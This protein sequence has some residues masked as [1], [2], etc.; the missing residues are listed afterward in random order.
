MNTKADLARTLRNRRLFY[1]A[2]YPPHVARVQSPKALV[3]VFLAD[4]M[5]NMREVTVQLATLLDRD[6][7]SRT[8]GDGILTSCGHTDPAAELHHF[9]ARELGLDPYND[10]RYSRI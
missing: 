3:R 8:Y 4:G 6:W 10:L 2:T 7:T 1:M 9:I 5:D